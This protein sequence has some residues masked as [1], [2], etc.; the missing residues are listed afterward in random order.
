MGWLIFNCTKHSD[1]RMINLM[2]D[3][4]AFHPD[5]LSAIHRAL[6]EDIGTGDITTNQHCS[7]LMHPCEDKSSPNKTE[8]L[9]GLDVAK[10]C[11]SNR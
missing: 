5:I 9:P 11:L 8:S 2:N 10:D 4:T 7:M 6:T 3:I 1:W